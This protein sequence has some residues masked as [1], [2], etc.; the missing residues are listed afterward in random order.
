MTSVS[1]FQFSLCFKSPRTPQ[2]CGVFVCLFFWLLCSLVLPQI[3]HASKTVELQARLES[4]INA[5]DQ[6]KESFGKY[7]IEAPDL[8]KKIEGQSERIRIIRDKEIK[9]AFELLLHRDLDGDR[10]KIWPI[11]KERQR[12]EIKGYQG[13][14]DA[15]KGYKNQTHLIKWHLKIEET[16]KI[17]KEFCHFFQLKAVGTHNVDAP[18]LTLSGVIRKRTPQLQLQCWNGDKSERHFLADWEAC[19]GKWLQC[20]VQC[21]YGK[22]GSYKFSVHSLDGT[23]ESEVDQKDFPSWREGFEF[24]RPKWGIYRSLATVKNQLNPVDSVFLNHFSIQK[25]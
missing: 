2:K 10:D 11:G 15:L 6:I 9:S 3:A 13:S 18:I 14:D 12:N 1:L 4:K 17:T 21:L 7:S 8:L 16:F 25:R 23:I 24:V 19:Q 20:T 22:K 5:V